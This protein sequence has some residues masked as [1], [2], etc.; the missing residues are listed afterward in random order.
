VEAKA[1]RSAYASRIDTRVKTKSDLQ[2]EAYG[3]SLTMLFSASR[4]MSAIV[5]S[6]A[7]EKGIPYRIVPEVTVRSRQGFSSWRLDL[8]GVLSPGRHQN[9]YW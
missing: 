4:Q 1:G 7:V 5:Q 3:A 8:T 9:H 6:A 2:K